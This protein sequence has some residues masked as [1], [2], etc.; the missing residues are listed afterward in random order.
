MTTAH[1]RTYAIGDRVSLGCT[2][3][4]SRPKTKI[5]WFINDISVPEDYVKEVLDVPKEENEIVKSTTSLLEFTLQAEHIVHHHSPSSSFT[6]RCSSMMAARFLPTILNSREIQLDAL[7]VHTPLIS[8]LQ[9]EY[10]LG[11]W[12]DLNC[13]VPA[14]MLGSSSQAEKQN[15]NN[16][17]R[18]F[19]SRSISLEW[20]INGRKVS[21]LLFCFSY[22]FAFCCCCLKLLTM[23]RNAALL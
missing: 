13:T 8:G 11:D 18:R 23:H 5:N 22:P 7:H 12:V 16:K 2:S 19:S 20:H 3:S 17:V 21:A 15:G 6:V 9:E 10:E 14:L 4:P 1:Q